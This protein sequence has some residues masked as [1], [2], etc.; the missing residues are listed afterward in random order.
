MAKKC[1]F[2]SGLNNSK[3]V[4][5]P[6]K[7]FTEQEKHQIIKE[8]MSSYCTKQ[9]IWEKYTGSP[10]EHGQLKKWMRQ[11][12]YDTSDK[13]R[14]LSFVKNQNVMAMRKESEKA[15]DKASKSFEILQLEKRV[16]ELEK[17]L[18]DVEMKAIA[19]STMIDIAE[20][21][22]NIPIR[23]KINTKP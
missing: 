4:K 9:Y 12:G 17:L 6:Y 7:Y 3:I 21:E 18:K 10:E 23:K 19:Y 1:K 16:L 22:F 5:K 8:L 15:I 13:T 14:R 2:I 20:K 11:L